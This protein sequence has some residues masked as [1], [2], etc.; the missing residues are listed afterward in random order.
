VTGRPSRWQG[1]GGFAVWALAGL[2]LAFTILSGFSIGFLIAPFAVVALMV[3]ARRAGHGPE[4]TGMVLGTGVTLSVIGLLN[5]DYDPC[6]DRVTVTLEVG[7]EVRCGGMDPV[8]WL[9]AGGAL[10]A[11]SIALYRAGCVVPL[12]SRRNCPTLG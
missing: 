3:A 12:P 11:L 10:A 7:E 8:P 1:A 2:L 6:P 5:L 9:L 4:A